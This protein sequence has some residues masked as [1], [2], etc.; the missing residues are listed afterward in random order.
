MSFRWWISDAK[1]N[2]HMW[3][4]DVLK[5]LRIIVGRINARSIDANQNEGI[6][7][8]KPWQLKLFKCVT[9]HDFYVVIGA[10]N[11]LIATQYCQ[12]YNNFGFSLNTSNQ[13]LNILQSNY[14]W[15]KETMYDVSPKGSNK[16]A[17]TWA[18]GSTPMSIKGL[19]D[20]IVVW[21]KDEVEGEEDGNIK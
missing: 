3:L 11:A 20:W 21:N 12:G 4:I 2:I 7:K 13:I 5:H 18:F 19:N 8:I 1:F 16:I 17:F 10:Y 15:N 14:K 6:I 9:P